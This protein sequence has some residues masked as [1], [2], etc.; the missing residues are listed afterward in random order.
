MTFFRFVSISFVLCLL[1]CCS[2]CAYAAVKY[3]SVCMKAVKY[4]SKRKRVPLDVLGAV[5]LTETGVK[6]GKNYLPWPWAIN[7]EGKG[8]LFK[9][10][11]SAILA[12]LKHIAQG[13]DSIDIG[14][15]QMNWKWHHK[16]FGSS[17]VHAFDP[18]KNVEIAANY[19]KEHFSIY[20]NWTR[21]IGRYHSGTQAYAKTYIS[22]AMINRNVMR[23]SLGLSPLKLQYAISQKE[24]AQSD[25]T[26]EDPY[27]DYPL[28]ARKKDTLPEAPRGQGHFFDSSPGALITFEQVGRPLIDLPDTPEPL[29]TRPVQ[30]LIKVD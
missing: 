2:P 5:A 27:A 15:M 23:S 10:K 21:A 28:L 13:K 18:Y 29:L 19:L 4:I 14:C 16:K 22:K 11:Q 30:P 26:P 25:I 7:V 12:T 1:W 24:T 3:N 6:R 9:D 17:V 8:Y 20:K